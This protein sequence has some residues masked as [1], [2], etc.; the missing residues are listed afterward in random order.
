MH[1]WQR[2]TPPCCPLATRLALSACRMAL[3]T[4][5]R[6]TSSGHLALRDI[7]RL[8]RGTRFGVTAGQRSNGLEPEGNGGRGRV[9]EDEGAQHGDHGRRG[10]LK[11]ANV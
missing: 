10:R 9:S 7:L 3:H 2:E 8:D 11:D 1:S 5:V 4:A 6:D